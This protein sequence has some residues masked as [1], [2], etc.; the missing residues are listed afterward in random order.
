M[1]LRP[2]G[3]CL[4]LAL[5][6]L[7][8]GLL[9]HETRP[10]QTLALDSPTGTP[11]PTSLQQSQRGAFHG[12]KSSTRFSSRRGLEWVTES[13]SRQEKK[14]AHSD[15]LS[16]K[17]PAFPGQPASGGGPASQEG[18][19]LQMCAQGGRLP[20]ALKTRLDTSASLRAAQLSGPG[21]PLLA[22]G[23][24]SGEVTIYPVAKSSFQQSFSTVPTLLG[25]GDSF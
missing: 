16:Q 19:E 21:L 11:H 10:V 8:P 23:Q 6:F 24:G 3:S 2:H 14:K 12:F 15:L 1:R 20:S 7:S 18:K 17:F 9:A 22:L 4:I 13:Y 5:W 25:T